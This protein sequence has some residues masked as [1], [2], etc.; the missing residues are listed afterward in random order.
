MNKKRI[1]NLLAAVLVLA[2]LLAA[3]PMASAS[4]D[5]VILSDD[6]SDFVL[7]SEAVPD[8]I[9]E[10]RYYSTY[11]F[12]G[13]R[14][15]GYEEP[16][17]FLTKEAAAA[18][19]EVSDELV[20]MGY[21]LK[22][23]DAYRPQRAVTHFMRWALDSEDTRMKEY[24]YPDLEKDVLFPQGY[25]AEHSG[26]SR[27]STVDLTLFDM[28]T[29]KEVDMGGTFDFFGLLSHPDYTDITEQQY[30]NRMLLREVMLKHGFKP[31]EE[32][33][34]HFTL[35]EE[36]YPDTYFT[37]PINSDSLAAEEADDG[38]DYA[39]LNNWAYY[40]IGEDR[41][42]DL[43]LVCPTVDM[44]DEFNMSME[45]E[46]TKADFLGA[47]NMERGIYEDDT[48]MFAPYYRQAAM[49]VYG[50][51]RTEWDPY[52]DLAYRDVSDAF[53]YYLE[54]ENQGRPIILAG[55]SQGAYMCYRLLAEYFGDEAL[56]DQLVA[57]YAIGWPCAVELTEEYP[58]IVPAQSAEDLGVVISF[59]CEAPELT[60]TIVS[61]A[62][63]K[64]YGINPLNWRTDGVVA[65]KSE[66]LGACFTSYSGRIRSETEALCGCYLDTERGVVKVIDV[67][68]ADYP[69][70]IPGF[71]EGAYHIYDYQFFFRNLQ[72]NVTERLEAYLAAGALDVAA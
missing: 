68:P 41:D 17:A 7:L 33:W 23:F 44:Q 11:N 45:D 2:V 20:A 52:M 12:V 42:A 25:I 38:I 72:Q 49:K 21:R 16:L 60:E 50:L 64:A 30:A 15:D 31:L 19:R 27:G 9:L 40:G 55:F 35:A 47:L 58:Q 46:D 39:D 56:Y 36:P 1:V 26:H 34:W 54:H 18:L 6:A 71:P 8:A 43:F 14:I 63:Q 29:E 4:A 32:E 53:S 57:V 3:V 10:I 28:R 24:F 51:D 69:A 65:D 22:I 61:P 59:D 62:G 66:N 13:D 67:D 70:I 37:F 5:D 48:R